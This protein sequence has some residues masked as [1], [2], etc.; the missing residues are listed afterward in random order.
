MK[1]RKVTHIATSVRQRLLNKARAT[2]RPFNELL[3]YFAMERFLYRLSRSPHGE[4]FV[5]KGALMLAMWEVSLTR[6]TKDID[7]LGHV[8]NDIDRIVSAVKEVCAQEVEPDGLDFDQDGVRGG[9]DR[10]G[11]RI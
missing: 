5:L 6:P 9:A 1:H 2:D 3:Q 11:G 4:K 7:L 8:P 10:R